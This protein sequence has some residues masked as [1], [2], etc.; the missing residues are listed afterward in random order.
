MAAGVTS[1]IMAVD[2]FTWLND[3]AGNVLDGG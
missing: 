3:F 2:L 1:E